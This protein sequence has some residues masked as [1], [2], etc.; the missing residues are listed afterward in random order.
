MLWNL[1]KNCETAATGCCLSL[2]GNPLR[3]VLLSQPKYVSQG[4][5]PEIVYVS[6]AFYVLNS[7]FFREMKPNT[8][9]SSV[10]FPRPCVLCVVNSI[11]GLELDS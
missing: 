4:F 3:Y 1:R 9:M 11:T 10:M 8:V 5:L 2:R 6:I 7:F